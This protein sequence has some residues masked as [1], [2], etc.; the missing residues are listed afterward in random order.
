MFYDFEE[1]DR[2]ATPADAMR[3]FAYNVGDYD[4]YKD[5]QWILTDYDV[6]VQNPHYRGPPQLHPELACGLEFEE[7]EEIERRMAEEWLNPT[8]ENTDRVIVND[9]DIPF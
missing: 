6:W 9:D 7:Y 4:R 8:A 3:E 1:E 2:V 5:R